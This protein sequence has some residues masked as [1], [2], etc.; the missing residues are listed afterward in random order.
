MEN[1]S[2]N[3]LFMMKNNSNNTTKTSKNKEYRQLLD[4]KQTAFTTKRSEK[5]LVSKESK[6]SVGKILKL[7]HHKV[8]KRRKKKQ[9]H[10]R[11][12]CSSS[13]WKLFEKT[14]TLSKKQETMIIK[15]KFRSQL[16]MIRKNCIAQGLNRTRDYTQ[17]KFDT[18]LKNRNWFNQHY[19][20]ADTNR[21]PLWWSP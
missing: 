9:L 6:S 10:K 8:S 7:H 21:T 20:E 17:K 14:I 18:I 11:G 16:V 2:S 12:D 5:Y 4:R 3:K 1:W 15:W 19:R 13:L